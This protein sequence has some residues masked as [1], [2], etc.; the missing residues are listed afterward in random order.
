M[1]NVDAPMPNPY[2]VLED[3]N[4]GCYSTLQEAREACR[5][6]REESGNDEIY[7][8]ALMGVPEALRLHPDAFEL[9]SGD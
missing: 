6:F 7:V 5:R 8:Y 4:G 3:E 9:G 1:L 2:Q